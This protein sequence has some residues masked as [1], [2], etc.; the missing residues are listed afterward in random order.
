M[1]A[2]TSLLIAAA[3][4]RDASPEQ[5][6]SLE[7]RLLRHA[8][9]AAGL[10]GRA[11][12]AMASARTWNFLP[13]WAEQHVLPGIAA[14]FRWRKRRIEGW[15]RDA[16][17]TGIRQV[18]VLGAGLD[19]LP[20]RF[21]SGDRDLQ[22]FEV[23]RDEAIGLKRRALQASFGHPANLHLVEADLSKQRVLEALTTSPAFDLA[24]PT[25]VIAEGLAMYL[26]AGV[27]LRNARDMA[28]RLHPRSL[29]IAT[30]MQA[31]A[32]GRPAFASQPR[33]LGT[34]LAISGEAFQWGLARDAIED[35]LARANL[36]LRSLADPADDPCPGESL[37]LAAPAQGFA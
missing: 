23:D 17:D 34:W 10:R 12:H 26:P 28:N 13:R 14:H 20:V 31:D 21:A 19:S 11:L 9:L 2:T 25:L 32:H 22:V 1:I 3:W 7:A 33:W 6:D 27:V 5:R 15:A 4:L 24:R 8:L 16:L 30:A 29:I 35:A 18:V 37:F 36:R